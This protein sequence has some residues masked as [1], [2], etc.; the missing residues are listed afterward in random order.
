MVTVFGGERPAVLARELTKTFETSHGGTLQ[1]LL[2]WL[3][4]DDNQLRGEFVI[5]LHGR[6]GRDAADLDAG[7][8][9]VLEVLLEDL[10]LKQAASLAARITGVPKNRLY[11][12]GLELKNG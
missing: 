5:M 8:R 2:D 12:Y 9:K 3:L 1:E 4:G 10:P 7:D 6:P 11:D